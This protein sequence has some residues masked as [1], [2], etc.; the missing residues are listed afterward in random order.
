MFYVQWNLLVSICCVTCGRNMFPGSLSFLKSE[1]KF[2]VVF[3]L[4]FHV[5]KD[6]DRLVALFSPYLYYNFT[7]V[8]HIL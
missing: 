8:S 7:L 2:V 5:E 6:F 3:E 4:V 1:Y